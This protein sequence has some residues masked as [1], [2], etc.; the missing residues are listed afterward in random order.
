LLIIKGDANNSL[1]VLNPSA[2]AFP[3]SGLSMGSDNTMLDGARWR[4]DRLANGTCVTLWKEK[5]RQELPKAV[6]CQVVGQRLQLKKDQIF[7]QGT[8]QIYYE[9]SLVGTCE[10]YQQ[11]CSVTITP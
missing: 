2:A 6:Q 8:F 11:P 5:Q 4:I 10:D 9:G 1:I 3:L 7:W